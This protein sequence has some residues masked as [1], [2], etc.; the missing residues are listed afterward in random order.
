MRTRPGGACANGERVGV[1]AIGHPAFLPG[2]KQAPHLPAP[3]GA[4]HDFRNLL[5]SGPVLPPRRPGHMETN[6]ATHHFTPNVMA[7]VENGKQQ[8]L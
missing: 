4:H 8:V 5:V 2:A 1:L 7:E 6:E 3:V